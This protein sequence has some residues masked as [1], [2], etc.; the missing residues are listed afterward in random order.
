MGKREGEKKAKKKT[1]L[2]SLKDFVFHFIISR[3]WH[4]IRSLIAFS[5]IRRRASK[6]KSVHAFSIPGVW[7]VSSK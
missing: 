7:P 4:N 6:K 3:K 2:T 5:F 1:E